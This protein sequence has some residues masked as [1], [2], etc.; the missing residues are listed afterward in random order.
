VGAAGF[1][2][3][4]WRRSKR[5]LA[6]AATVRS[7]GWRIG[8]EKLTMAESRIDRLLASL[9]SGDAAQIKALCHPDMRVEDPESLP[10]G[11]VYRGFAGMCEVSGKLFAAVKNWKCETER[12]IG[13]P[14]GDE[15]VLV[16]R[17]TGTSAETG[18][19]IDMSIL[20]HY[21]FRDGLLVSIRPYYWDTKAMLDSLSG[22]SK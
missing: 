21:A 5:L 20:E 14:N 6:P 15:F 11:G 8:L 12:V 2:H 10:Y 17:M 22:S 18:Q 4:K 19:P 3:L 1:H 16:Q 13:D 7:Y 9:R